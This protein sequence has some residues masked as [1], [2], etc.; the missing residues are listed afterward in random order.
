[1]QLKRA[2]PIVFIDL[3]NVFL[4]DLFGSLPTS[5]PG[6]AAF[7]QSQPGHTIFVTRA[8]ESALIVLD[9]YT[10]FRAVIGRCFFGFCYQE[11]SSDCIYVVPC[12]I[13]VLTPHPT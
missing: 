2:F 7:L 5:Q 4:P 11:Y 12:Y 8:A 1:V 6:E 10:F 13:V 9:S 3:V